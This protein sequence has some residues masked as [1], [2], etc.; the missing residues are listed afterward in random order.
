[1]PELPEVETI[2]RGLF[3]FVLKKKIVKVKVFEN[4]SFL[5][6][7][8]EVKGNCINN[9]Y[10]L[11]KALFFELSN[12]KTMM[13]HLR[14]TGQIVY[15]GKTERFGGGHPSENFV[16]ILPNKQTRIEFELDDG[17]KMFFNDQRKFGFFKVIDSEKVESEA[18]VKKLGKEPFFMS[19]GELYKKI[20][21]KSANIKSV[22]LDQ[23]IMSG[24][25]N[26]Y[27]D[28]TLFDVGI[29]PTRICNTLTE[30]ECEQ[31]VCSAR[32]VLNKSIDAGGSTIKNYVKADGTRG[33]YLKLF[34]KVYGREGEICEKCGAKIKKMRTAGRGTYYCERCQK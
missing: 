9:L 2:K 22:L 27:T 21:N 19:G 6:D 7:I 13:A 5:G 31:I 28:E 11:G 20:K 23:T 14:M 33:D 18:F 30:K 32:K 25:G 29:L 17:S 10:R 1:M 15:V 16:D 34:A 12:G 8:S 4:K 26:I 3:D 24:L